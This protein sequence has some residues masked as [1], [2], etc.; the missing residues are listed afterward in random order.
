MKKILLATTLLA[1][2]AG[3]AS[4]EVAVSGSARMGIIYDGFTD[5]AAF[6]SRVRIKFAATGTTDGGLSFGATVRNDQIGTGGTSN[7]DSTVF[8]SGAFGSLTM[9]DT[10]NASD[11]L[12]G[13]VSGIGYGPGK[14]DGAADVK[15]LDDAVKTAV[16][17][18]YTSGALTFGLGS[19]QTTDDYKS[20]AVA[21][22]AGSFQVAVGYEDDGFDNVT[23]LKGTATFG[24]ATVKVKVA[25]DSR[26]DDMGYALSVDYA[27]SPALTVTGF[28]ADTKKLT[29]GVDI[30]A[31]YGIGASYDLGGGAKVKG[32]VASVNGETAADF[33][34]TMDF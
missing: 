2:T 17:Y 32:G 9:G 25:D 20:I 1:A 29:G 6:S 26:R 18:K 16:Y 21:Y 33:G 7:G 31:N 8:I 10:G 30:D 19:G 3:Y 34:V 5:D 11:D 27:A 23:S 4:A 28:Y 24:A 22:D 15:L 12:V 13:Q 14:L